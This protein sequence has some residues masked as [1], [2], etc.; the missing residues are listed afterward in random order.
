MSDKV[1]KFRYVSTRGLKMI[2]QGSHG[3]VYQIDDDTI[4]KIYH[5]NSSLEQIDK[6][7]QFARFAF[8]RGIPSAITFDVVATEEGLGIVFEL[9]GGKPLGS[10]LTEHPEEREEYVGKFAEILKQLNA[11][12][13]DTSLLG[14]VKDLY[15]ERIQRGG[16][17]YSEQDIADLLEILASLPDGTSM[18]HGDYH[19]QNLM[20]TDRGELMLID[21]ANLSYGHGFFDIGGAYLTHV[22]AAKLSP[23]RAKK[24]TGLDKKTSFAVWRQLLSAYYDTTD[25]QILALREKQCR[26]FGTFRMCASVGTNPNHSRLLDYVISRFVKRKVIA[27]KEEFIRVFSEIK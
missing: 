20:V 12:P 11:T 21:M 3:K 25:E 14:S 4:I 22:H 7:R 16:K 17:Y 27:K 10:F 15:A 19:T 26:Y 1:K 2:G 23:K 18:I 9:A 5:D 8:L 24:I 13:A 6:E